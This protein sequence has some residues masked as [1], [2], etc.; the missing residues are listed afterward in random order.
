MIVSK[1]FKNSAVK[2]LIQNT[3]KDSELIDKYRVIICRQENKKCFGQM[4][5]CP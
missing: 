4:L 5:N 3:A 2:P 1:L